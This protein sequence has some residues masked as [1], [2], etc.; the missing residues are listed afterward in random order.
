MS[1]PQLVHGFKQSIENCNT[2][3]PNWKNDL[4]RSRRQKE[5]TTQRTIRAH[6]TGYHP[7]R[8]EKSINFLYKI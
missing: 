6:C 4:S 7:A 3:P 1:S 5:G 2:L 8:L